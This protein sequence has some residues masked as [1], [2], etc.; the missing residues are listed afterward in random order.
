MEVCLGRDHLTVTHRMKVA[1]RS[2]YIYMLENGE[3]TKEG[4]PSKLQSILETV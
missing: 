1:Q 4:K 2:D 3:I